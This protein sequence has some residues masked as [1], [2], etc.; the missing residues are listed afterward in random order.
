MHNRALLIGLIILIVICFA[1][2]SYTQKEHFSSLDTYYKMEPSSSKP[3]RTGT[4]DGLCDGEGGSIIPNGVPPKQYVQPQT[5]GIFPQVKLSNTNEAIFTG[6]MPNYQHFPIKG[7][8]CTVPYDLGKDGIQIIITSQMYGK[9][10][11]FTSGKMMNNLYTREGVEGNPVQMWQVEGVSSTENCFVYIHSETSDPGLNPPYYLEAR[12]DGTV[13]V[14]LL[15]KGKNKQWKIVPVTGSDTIKVQWNRVMPNIVNQVATVINMPNDERK[16]FVNNLTNTTTTKSLYHLFTISGESISIFVN[17]IKKFSG[18]TDA[19]LQNNYGVNTTQY[20]VS[21]VLDMIANGVSEN[22]TNLARI[23]SVQFG[24]YLSSNK[25]GF[26]G[27][28][29]SVYLVGSA[30]GT[31]PDTLWSFTT[32]SIEGFSVLDYVKKAPSKNYKPVL[33]DKDLPTLTKTG[34]T[35]GG[36]SPDFAQAWNGSYIYGNSTAQDRTKLLKVNLSVGSGVTGGTGI[37]QFDGNSYVVKPVTNDRL[38]SLDGKLQLH[39]ISGT[40]VNGSLPVMKVTLNGNSVCGDP[41]N[42]D[43]LCLKIEGDQLTTD[44]DYK[45][46][47]GVRKIDLSKGLGGPQTDLNAKD[48]NPCD[49]LT[50]DMK[51]TRDCASFLWYSKNLDPKSAEWKKWA[52]TNEKEFNNLVGWF[53]EQK[54]GYAKSVITNWKQRAVANDPEMLAKCKDIAPC[55]ADQNTVLKEGQKCCTGMKQMG[56]KCIGTPN[57]CFGKMGENQYQNPLYKDQCIAYTWKT[58]GCSN[59]DGLSTNRKA[60]EEMDYDTMKGKIQSLVNSAKDGNYTSIKSCYAP[61]QHGMYNAPDAQFAT[62]LQNNCAPGT[63]FT[64]VDHNGKFSECRSG[65]KKACYNIDVVQFGDPIFLRFPKLINPNNKTGRYLSGGKTQSNIV[66][67]VVPNSPYESSQ[68]NA[69]TFIPTKEVYGTVGTGTITYGQKFGL[70][71]KSINRFLSGSRGGDHGII[72]ANPS[73]KYEQEVINEAKAGKDNSYYWCF[74]PGIGNYKKNGEP[75]VYRDKVMLKMYKW[76]DNVMYGYSDNSVHNDS[77]VT[78]TYKTGGT[79]EIVIDK[80]WQYPLELYNGKFIRGKGDPSVYLVANTMRYHLENFGNCGP[81]S[82]AGNVI[83]V[84]MS[85]IYAIR[86]SG[87]NAKSVC[88]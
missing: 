33:G 79:D 37:V 88:K 84:P 28:D 27:K 44:S 86:N 59:V 1:I 9:S 12:K 70:K 62:P 22:F 81:E 38:Q 55:V 29:G 46:A 74:A 73:S 48:P 18:L 71:C 3:D 76:G 65:T 85:V 57:P 87:Q 40:G 66:V 54:V 78:P 53:E 42:I 50:D 30:G 8:E 6:T 25:G 75:V 45:L 77:P 35:L 39:L 24:T 4:C 5:G 58:I 43:A 82:N 11:A 34:Q 2:R 52:C 67:E 63:E 17:N 60:Y 10:L 16:K 20:P 21:M 32:E 51:M 15:S 41:Q 68:I 61:V 72:T 31:S 14:S 26:W 64:C 80:V 49:G 83:D 23:Q 7:D 13:R 47:M 36:W 19:D 69:Y 56:N